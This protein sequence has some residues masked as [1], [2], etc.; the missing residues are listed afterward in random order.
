MMNRL[1][2]STSSERV[3]ISWAVAGLALLMLVGLSFSMGEPEAAAPNIPTYAIDEELAPH[4]VRDCRHGL[5]PGEIHVDRL[6]LSRMAGKIRTRIV[7]DLDGS[8]AGRAPQS[9]RSSEQQ[10]GARGIAGPSKGWIRSAATG[11]APVRCRRC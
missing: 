3:A 2:P 1:M 7:P 11:S 6:L 9:V 5:R 10:K 4:N 8:T